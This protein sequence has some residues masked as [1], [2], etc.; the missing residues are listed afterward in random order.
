VPV[1]G[2]QRLVFK[3]RLSRLSFPRLR[4]RDESSGKD[5]VKE[6]MFLRHTSLD[7]TEHGWRGSGEGEEL[8]RPWFYATGANSLAFEAEEPRLFYFRETNGFWLRWKGLKGFLYKEKI[9]YRRF[10]VQIIDLD[11]SSG[12]RLPKAIDHLGTSKNEN[13]SRYIT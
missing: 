13:M 6:M 10:R 8:P 4:R 3:G 12:C 7:K 9:I 11:Q 1:G 5:A 2:W